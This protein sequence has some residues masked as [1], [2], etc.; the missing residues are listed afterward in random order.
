MTD[1]LDDQRGALAGPVL[2]FLA[3]IVLA[4]ILYA[5][6]VPVGETLTDQA[7]DSAEREA[8]VHGIGYVGMIWGN[9][10]FIAVAFGALQF[11]ARSV[12]RG[13]VPGGGR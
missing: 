12:F 5:T 3:T 13:R 7:L 9:L 1:F 11:L 2:V 6:V 8:A 4:T 10:H